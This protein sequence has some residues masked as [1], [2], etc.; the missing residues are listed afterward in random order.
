MPSKANMDLM[1]SDALNIATIKV[2]SVRE[3]RSSDISEGCH[4]L[5]DSGFI[6]VIRDHN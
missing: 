5:I 4:C 6:S 1:G 2:V 3:V